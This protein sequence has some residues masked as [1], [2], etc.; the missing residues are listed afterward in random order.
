MSLTAREITDILCGC[1]WAPHKHILVPNVSWG[2][3][4]GEADLLVMF[5]SL[6]C[7]EVEVKISRADFRRE[8]ATKQ[9][10]HASLMDRATANSREQ[11]IRRYWF[12]FPRELAESLL[13]EVPSYA[14]VIAVSKREP[15]LYARMSK[16]PLGTIGDC[17]VLRPAPALKFARKLTEEEARQLLRL[18]H[19]RYWS[20]RKRNVDLGRKVEELA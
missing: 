14:G 16:R 10:K 2:L 3:L 6:W 18:A 17:T 9:L 19:L 12:A 5:D 7:E 1:H 4:D 15:N 20:L 8:F 13:S 11:L